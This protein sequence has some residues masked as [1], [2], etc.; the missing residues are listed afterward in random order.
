[1]IKNIEQKINIHAQEDV[2]S[3]TKT[4]VTEFQKIE[5]QTKKQFDIE[6]FIFDFILN[7]LFQGQKK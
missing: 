4:K 3:M 1:M 6:K 2:Y 5:E 7:F